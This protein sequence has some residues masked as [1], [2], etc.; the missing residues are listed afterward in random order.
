MTVR[1]L[2]IREVASLDEQELE[3]VAR[4]VHSLRTRPSE[5]PLPKWNFAM[6]GASTASLRRSSACRRRLR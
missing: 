1:E 4:I 6:Y 2:V 5:A 3:Y